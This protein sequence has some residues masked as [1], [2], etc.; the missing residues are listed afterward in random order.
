MFTLIRGE[1]ILFAIRLGSYAV[2]SKTKN[3]T[4]A[5]AIVALSGC[6]MLSTQQDVESRAVARDKSLNKMDAKLL[7][8]VEKS[9]RVLAT[10]KNSLRVSLS[11]EDKM[12][13]DEW[14]YSVTPDGMG[15]AMSID[16]WTG[17]LKS[18]VEMIAD[19]TGYTVEEVGVAQPNARN[20]TV[21]GVGKPAI[22][23]LRNV[24]MQAGCDAMVKPV[25]SA[26]LIV[27]DWTY[28]FSGGCK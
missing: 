5:F 19:F 26:R 1:C 7:L 8:S 23:H 12:L 9:L 27:I 13:K 3:V 2:N 17:S 15:E 21:G 4:L 22:D 20:V 10:T 18:V 16:P 14:M 28:R 24:A 11:S 25:S 6:S